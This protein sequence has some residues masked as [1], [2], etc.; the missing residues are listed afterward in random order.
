AFD[1]SPTALAIARERYAGESRVDHMEGDLIAP[2]AEWAGAFDFVFEAYT[3]QVLPPAER[4]RAA[5]SLRTL[6]AP[7]GTLL[8]VARAREPK[9]PE[10]AMPWPLLRSEIDA[11]AA[12]DLA[13]EGAR[14][15]ID[16]ETPPV[17][18]WIATYVRRQ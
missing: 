16:D 14:D 5:A 15:V 17:R 8:V 4:A 2:R 11:I 18:R 9:D 7:G 12:G 6:V 13:L 10:G 3:L 1:I